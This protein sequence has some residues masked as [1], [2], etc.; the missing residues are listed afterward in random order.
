MALGDS[1]AAGYGAVPATQGYVYLL[2]QLGVFD[3]IERILFCNAGVPGA[4]SLDVLEHQV[5]LAVNKFRPTTITISVGGNDL[6]PLR[7]GAELRQVLHTFRTNLGQILQ[8]LRSGLPEAKIYL[9]NLYSI[10]GIPET[11][12]I[13][14]I[15]NRLISRVARAFDV[16]VADVYSAFRGKG[17]LLGIEHNGAPRDEVHPT[18]AGYRVMAHAFEEVVKRQG[19][20]GRH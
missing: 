17:G 14:P 6:L 1:L 9:N 3:S 4:S 18:N 16:P 11:V 19:G 2:Y 8:R 13:V 7:D 12:V 10:P 15:L 5:P 20:N